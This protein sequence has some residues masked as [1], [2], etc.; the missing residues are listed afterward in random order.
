MIEDIA[1]TA[2]YTDANVI[3]MPACNKT[4]DIRF[5]NPIISF[6]RKGIRYKKKINVFDFSVTKRALCQHKIAV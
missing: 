4:A 5:T 3:L 1:K 2:P 6:H